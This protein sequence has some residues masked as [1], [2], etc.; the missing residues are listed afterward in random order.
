MKPW[1]DVPYATPASKQSA[2]PRH[3]LW[4]DGVGGFLLLLAAHA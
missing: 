3:L 1:H 2:T 4:I